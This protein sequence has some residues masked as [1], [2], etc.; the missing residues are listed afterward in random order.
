LD[1]AWNVRIVVRMDRSSCLDALLQA[2]TL[3]ALTAGLIGCGDK[4]KSIE[5]EPYL[6]P[7]RLGEVTTYCMVRTDSDDFQDYVEG[8]EF[9]WG[10][11][12]ELTIIEHEIEKPEVDGPSKEYSLLELGQRKAVAPGT[13][14]ELYWFIGPLDEELLPL[15]LGGTCPDQLTLDPRNYPK[16]LAFGSDAECQAFLAAAKDGTLKH[17]TLAFGTPEAPLDVI[18]FE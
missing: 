4:I 18:A 17:L 9:K 2:G 8:F 6:A 5:L 3:A 7:C 11:R 10:Y 12:T 16:D 14:F 15:L 1:P 13:Q